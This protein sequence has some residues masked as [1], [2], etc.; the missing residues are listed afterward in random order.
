MKLPLMKNCRIDRKEVRSI[1]FTLLIDF[2]DN[3]SILFSMCGC[4]HSIKKVYG[5]FKWL[6]NNMDISKYCPC[7]IVKEIKGVKY[8]NY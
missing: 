6:A 2:T 1:W 3:D 4:E 5:E 8:R 7:G